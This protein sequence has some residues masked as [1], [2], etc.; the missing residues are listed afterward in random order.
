MSKTK[1]TPIRQNRH[2]IHPRHTGRLVHHR[3]TSWVY[4]VLLL[5]M[6]GLLLAYSTFP[7]LADQV[8]VTATANGP[9]PPEPAVIT[10]PSDGA[11]VSQSPITVSGTCPAPYFIKL[12]RNQ[13]FSG[14]ARCQDDG[15]FSIVTDLFPGENELRALIFNYA[16]QEGPL[17]DPVIVTLIG[18]SGPAPAAP[19]LPPAGGGN[20][21]GGGGYDGAEA[22]PPFF[23]TTDKFYKANLDKLNIDWQFTIVGGSPSYDIDVDWG[24]GRKSKID[25]FIDKK[26]SVSHEYA[27][28]DQ[29]F[30]YYVVKVSVRDGSQRVATLQVFNILSFTE[31]SGAGTS[32]PT[33][34][35]AYPQDDGWLERTRYLWLAYGS[36]LLMAV[37]FWLGQHLI[38]A[39][40]GHGRHIRKLGPP[41]ARFKT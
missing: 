37:S 18:V 16:D 4:M 21:S 38:V 35:T 8:T 5:L 22:L 23:I 27:K 11:V 36:V 29:E 9:L 34:G 10:K 28:T 33:G 6:V 32:L 13:L 3:H 20:G 17:S 14:S 12:Y 24:N 41:R 1:K 15:T 31:S 30:N 19:G 26:F 2:L 7:V 39:P 40:A 25:N